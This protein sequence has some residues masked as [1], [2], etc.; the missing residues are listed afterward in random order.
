M[1]RT[2]SNILPKNYPS[3]LIFG[4]MSNIL[5]IFR[6]VLT[7]RTTAVYLCC[8]SNPHLNNEKLK[9][10]L[11][12]YMKRYTKG[13]SVS[14]AVSCIECNLATAAERKNCAA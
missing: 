2:V 8:L 14:A 4:S 11:I 12:A 13:M 1:Y 6:P 7:I 10:E 5:V 9:C 3:E